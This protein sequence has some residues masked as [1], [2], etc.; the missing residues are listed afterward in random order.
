MT[1][2]HSKSEQLT[3]YIRA[4]A[5]ELGLVFVGGPNRTPLLR[6]NNGKSAVTTTNVRMRRKPWPKVTSLSKT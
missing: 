2:L 4:K 5:A 3:K 6:T 1:N